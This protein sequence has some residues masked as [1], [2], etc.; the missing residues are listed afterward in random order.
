MI[1]VSI[2][3]FECIGS[4]ITIRNSMQDPTQFKFVF[5]RVCIFVSTLYVSFSV[6]SCISLSNNLNQIV[7]LDIEKKFKPFILFQAFYGL[8]LI[9]T[10]PM[11]IFPVVNIIEETKYIRQYQAVSEHSKIRR[12]LPRFICIILPI[13]IIALFNPK[14]TDV[15]NLVG[16]VAGTGL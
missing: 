1:G 16:A 5:K 10:L 13:I 7:I 3:A 12:Y 2:F 15:L 4:V 11:A 9:I 6:L 8:G 14:F